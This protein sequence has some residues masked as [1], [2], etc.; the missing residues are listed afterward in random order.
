MMTDIVQRLKRIAKES[1]AVF[2]GIVGKPKMFAWCIFWQCVFFQLVLNSR[3]NTVY[4]TQKRNVCFF[5]G[6]QGLEASCQSSAT[7]FSLGT[8]ASWLRQLHCSYSC[9]L[10]D[11]L[12]ALQALQ[13]T[14]EC[15]G[16]VCGVWE[17][18]VAGVRGVLPSD[19]LVSGL[20]CL[21]C[22]LLLVASPVPQWWLSSTIRS[23]SFT[24]LSL[25]PS[26]ADIMDGLNY[27]LATDRDKSGQD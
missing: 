22:L 18:E 26:L 9:D 3:N 21:L 17:R 24:D 27:T 13:Y 12:A 25:I 6:I 2:E 14:S 1:Q 20:V 19:D 16:H 23:D 5:P 8:Y 4:S 15:L 11:K 7:S 10:E